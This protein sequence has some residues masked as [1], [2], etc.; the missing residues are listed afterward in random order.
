V[1]LPRTLPTD[2]PSP[3]MMHTFDTTA[4]RDDL[5]AAAHPE[6]GTARAQTVSMEAP[7]LH[8]VI[9]EFDRRT[10]RAAVLNTSF[11]LHGFPIV[12][13]ACDAVDVLLRSSLENLIV[14]DMLVTKR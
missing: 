7:G 12:M 3:F 9:S 14:E 13:G 5:I 2:D 10:G 1:V 6:D 11:N 4:R 8:R